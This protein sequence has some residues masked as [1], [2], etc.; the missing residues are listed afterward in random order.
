LIV[1]EALREAGIHIM[2][3]EHAQAALDILEQH[4]ARINV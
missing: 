3:V 4:A 1:A 2:E